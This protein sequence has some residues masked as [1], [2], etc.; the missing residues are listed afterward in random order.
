ETFILH[1]RLFRKIKGFRYEGNVHNRPVAIGKVAKAPV[2]LIHYGYNETP[3]V[4]EVKHQRRVEMIRNWISEEPDNFQAHSYLAQTLVS[5]LETV[6]EGVQEA[7]TAMELAR[8]QGADAQRFPHIFYGLI[9]GLTSMSRD[10]EV[11]DHSRDC[12]NLVPSYPDPLF[13]TVGVYYKRHDWENVRKDAQLFEKLQEKCRA[14]PDDFLFF[15]N[16]TFN[17][18]NYVRMRW[19]IASAHLGETQEAQDVFEQML[20][21]DDAQELAKQVTQNL[22]TS[23]MPELALGMAQRSAASHPDWSWPAVLIEIAQQKT[24]EARAKAVKAEGLAAL[25]QGNT[26]QAADLLKQALDLSPTDAEALLSL[27]KALDEQGEAK[28]A[29]AWY[30][31]G[32]NA[33]PGHAWAW[34]RLAELLFS[35][36]SYLGAQACYRRYLQ[37]A[38]QDQAAQA[39]LDTC[40]R[41]LTDTGPTVAQSPPKLLLFLVGGLTHNMAR[42]AA[43]HFLMGTAWGELVTEPGA[44]ASNLPAWATL[45]T[46]A[47]PEIHGITSE[48]SRQNSLNITALKVKSIWDIL[49]QSHSLGLMAVPMGHPVPEVPGWAVAGYPAGLLEPEM[50]HPQDLAPLVLAQGFRADYVLTDFEEETRSQRLESHFRQEAFLCQLERNKLATAMNLPS[51]DVLAVGINAL[52]HIQQ[53]Y[54]LASYNAFMIYQQVYGWIESILA[55]LQ[56]ENFAVLSQRTYSDAGR[57][58]QPGGFYCLSWLRG[59]NDQAYPTALAAEILKVMGC[60]PGHLGQAR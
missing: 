8:Q 59:E 50:V 5:R 16:M 47:G 30:I 54:D 20:K 33:H 23:N 40:L 21:E 52:E 19:A 3:E 45:Y 14:Q 26:Q 51:V 53:S 32:L 34:Q 42:E 56:P 25:E 22:L 38:I 35:R 9:N 27:G 6:P 57:Q 31:R 46:G 13:F 10:D 12:L 2:K 60:D 24:E 7:F 15:E 28:Q 4:M 49:A 55:A 29:E 48:T 58:P 11:L 36:R 18:M 1:P 41:R 37:Q 43:P 44:S 17:Q 39:R